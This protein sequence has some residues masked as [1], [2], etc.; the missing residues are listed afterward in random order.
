MRHLI[1]S[2]SSS[3]N[4]DL[5]SNHASRPD[6]ESLIE[7]IA[8]R[9]QQSL[10]LSTILQTTADAV[11]QILQCDRIF[12][13]QFSEDQNNQDEFL[14]ELQS[15]ANL[16]IP[17]LNVSQHWGVF[18]AHNDIAR[19]WNAEEIHRLQQIA[20]HVGIA[21]RQ[22]SL[23]EQLRDVKEAMSSQMG[24][25]SFELKHTNH[26]FLQ[27][28]QK[29]RHLINNLHAGVVIHSPDTSV[30]FSNSNA[31]DLL[32]LTLEQMLGKTAIDPTWH[33]LREDGKDMPFEEYPV[34][35]VLR[36]GLP[37]KN[38]IVGI[39]HNSQT[40][41]W[42]IINAFPEF[43]TNQQIQQ[44][45]IT[46]IDISDRKKVELENRETQNFLNSIIENIPNMLFVK[47]AKDL[48]FVR[49]N[50]AGEE[51]LGYSRESLIGKS[52]YDFFPHEDADFFIAKDR[53]V[54]ANSKVLDIPEEVIQTKN[55]GKRILHTKKIP[56]F[57][58]SG[59]LQYLLG[60]SEDIT[61]RRQAEVALQESESRF[62]KIAL[63]SPGGI[64]ILVHHPD[65]SAYFEYASS[66]FEDICEVSVKQLTENLNTYKALIH[67][68]D[69]AG[70]QEAVE[71]SK[72]NLSPFKHS[73][74]IITPSQKLK[75][76]QVNSRN[77]YR[78]NGDIAW[79]GVM[80]D[81]TDLKQTEIALESAKEVAEAATKEKS[82]FLANMSH[83]I[84][85]PMNGV[86]GMAELL[87]KTNLTEDQQDIVQTIRD[88]GDALLVIINDI[89]D[90]SKIDSRMFQLEE[91]S[92]I[93]KDLILSVCSLLNNQALAKDI[94]IQYAISDIPANVVG[95]SIRLRQILLNLIGNAIKFTQ[96]SGSINISVTKNRMEDNRQLELTFSIVDTGVGIHCDR[97]NQ[98]FQPFTQA[99]PSISRKYG[100]TGLGLAISHSLVRLMGG[101]IWVES[102][103]NIGGNPPDGWNSEI[104]ETQ[105]SRFYFTI[106]LKVV[107]E[108]K[109]ISPE[110]LSHPQL[111]VNTNQSQYQ[112]LLAEDNLV[113]QKV[114]AMMLKKLGY[115]ADIANNGLEVL[116]MV[117]KRVY[118][119]ILMDM[120]M[121]EMDGV[122]ATK[123]IRQS[124]QPQPRIVA[125]T[126]N[127]LD[128][129]RQMCFDAGMNDFVTKP[130]L[131]Q[132][133]NRII[134][135]YSQTKSKNQ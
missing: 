134:S 96:N 71:Y 38:Y 76:V 60:I 36:T 17:L 101:D 84:R 54:L 117:E 67:P 91:H 105:G 92:F 44:I 131:I 82:Q 50:N 75:W 118:D 9:T 80:L 19:E 22:A 79:Y 113:N 115:I 65:G 3:N 108:T 43:D 28:E 124:N 123:I 5:I 41:V 24:G 121:P 128:E 116:Q 32:G 59:H 18:V 12:F 11:Q 132:E 40:Q 95:D 25:C 31:C 102:L 119:L 47:D 109:T 130:L 126:A 42:V 57:D 4:Q 51:L 27:S 81:I 8:L 100:G 94:N 63:S 45:V 46:F 107:S 88:S 16:V 106:N 70:Y 14:A 37:L 103:G 69:L 99:D 90:F 30:I 85:T 35:Q 104:A 112:I 72:K 2:N 133:L 53:E 58:E 89:L 114:A 10:A 93:V 23:L 20:I 66:A 87:A 62:Q 29:Y 64:Y 125:V 73:W 122:T 1:Q 110:T 33:F 49:F 26:K 78:D 48:K 83:E 98:L 6:W 120:Q 74:R 135:E 7:A 77:E 127:A 52:D 111:D 34:N 39:Y 55:K 13:Y 86:L 21:I 61:E 129:D 15:P 68:D 97:I 56:I